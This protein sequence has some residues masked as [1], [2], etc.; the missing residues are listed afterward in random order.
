MLCLAL[1]ESQICTK[2]SEQ[3]LQTSLTFRNMFGHQIR[4]LGRPFSRSVATG[5][6]G[7]D[8]SGDS[9]RHSL[10]VSIANRVPY[11]YYYYELVLYVKI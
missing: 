2:L 5:L 9:R 11:W 1:V 8:L 4:M 3:R 6:P 7:I 10:R